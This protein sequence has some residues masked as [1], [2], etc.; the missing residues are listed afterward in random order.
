MNGTDR[1]RVGLLF[2]VH[3]IFQDVTTL[4]TNMA[5]KNPPIEDVFPSESPLPC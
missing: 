5:M 1:R 2:F 4:K 3:L